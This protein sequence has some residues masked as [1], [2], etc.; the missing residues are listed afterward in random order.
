VRHSMRVTG[1]GEE[2]K[3]EE[4]KKEKKKKG[5]FT[6]LPPPLELKTHSLRRGKKG[7]EKDLSNRGGKEEGE[8]C[9]IY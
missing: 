4:K 5:N 6:L 2:N 7:G 9:P 3:E 1:A 8:V